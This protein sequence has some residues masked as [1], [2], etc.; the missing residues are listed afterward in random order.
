MNKLIYNEKINQYVYMKMCSKCNEEKELSEF[1]KNKS[2]KGGY[3]N[4]CKCCTK[5]RKKNYYKE[6]KDKFKNYREANKDR[7]NEYT[8]K[9]YKENKVLLNSK[10]KKYREDNPAKILE[11]NNKYYKENRDYIR[12]QHNEYIK[13]RR[14]YEP[15]YKLKHN[16]KSSI[17]NSMKRKGY[18]KKSRTYEILGCSFEE[19]M[20]Y[21]NDNPY[22]FLYGDGFFDLDHI[23]PLS[24]ATT[25]EEILELNHYSNFQLLPSD[26][27]Q[28]IKRDNE[29]DEEDFE[30]WLS[31]NN[32][33]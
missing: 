12:K 18:K 17:R 6:N 1:F 16:I 3:D 19:F 33:F 30:N 5:N 2:R 15:S 11:I 27:N 21:L 10:S 23:I 4:Q 24:S 25:E 28:H 22:N 31:E 7:I 32:K 29:W 9:Y 8:I 20:I 13:N 14:D 26:Y